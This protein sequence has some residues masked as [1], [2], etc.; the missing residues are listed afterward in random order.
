F[1]VAVSSATGA[2][3]GRLVAQVRVL[4]GDRSLDR[5]GA[6][7]LEGVEVLVAEELDADR[8]GRTPLGLR[9]V[10]EVRAYALCALDRLTVGGEVTSQVGFLQGAE[11]AILDRGT[12]RRHHD[13]RARDDDAKGD[14]PED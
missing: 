11:V 6:Q 8:F 13:G 4:E 5:L 14:D 2:R 10:I 12:S 3:S 1:Y 9:T 7:G